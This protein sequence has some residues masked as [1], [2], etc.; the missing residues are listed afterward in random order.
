LFFSLKPHDIKER[1]RQRQL[2]EARRQR[3]DGRSGGVRWP[4]DPPPAW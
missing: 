3:L 2:L 4:V 1:V